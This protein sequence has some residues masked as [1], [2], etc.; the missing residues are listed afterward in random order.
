MCFRGA[1]GAGQP[2]AGRSPFA[3]V[4][5]AG[6]VI[7]K[8]TKTH[9]S[10]SRKIRSSFLPKRLD[11]PAAQCEDLRKKEER[12]TRHSTYILLFF[13]GLLC[14]DFARLKSLRVTRWALGSWDR[15]RGRAQTQDPGERRLKVVEDYC[16]GG[17]LPRGKR[18]QIAKKTHLDSRMQNIC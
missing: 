3:L 10:K 4:F 7:R 1:F 6:S 17:R 14:F 18:F 15:G 5:Y 16:T 9:I 2:A 11:F 13:R 8:N 12:G